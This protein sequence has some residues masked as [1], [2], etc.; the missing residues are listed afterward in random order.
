[1]ILRDGKTRGRVHRPGFTLIELLV[2]VGIIAI[3]AGMLLPALARARQ[4]GDQTKCLSNLKQAG[5]AIH[6]YVNDHDEYFPG[7]C[8][9]G[10]RASYDQ[11][12]DTEFIWYVSS[13][14]G[15]APEAD[16][17]VANVFVCPGYVHSAPPDTSQMEGRIC[18]L[19][20]RDIDP[21]PSNTVRPFGYPPFNS[22][23][24]VMPLKENALNAYGTPAT[25]YAITDVDKINVPDPTVTWWS[26]LPYQPVHGKVRN[27]LYFDGHI[28]AKLW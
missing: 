8:W 3:L 2:V 26:D 25:I 21:S 19:L 23:P 9:T 10:A 1:M 7:P 18:Y 22:A 17:L 13:Y 12:S 15:K 16:T 20:N 5:M 14:L 6:M 27:E 28:A 11:G 4:K 24:E